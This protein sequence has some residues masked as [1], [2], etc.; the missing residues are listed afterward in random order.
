VAGAAS[1]VGRQRRPTAGPAGRSTARIADH[2]MSTRWAARAP[3]GMFLCNDC[4]DKFTVRTGAVF[5]RSHIPVAQ[6]AVG[7][8][9]DGRERA[10]IGP[11]NVRC[12]RSKARRGS[13]SHIVSLAQTSFSSEV[14]KFVRWQRH[15]AKREVNRNIN[16]GAVRWNLQLTIVRYKARYA[17]FFVR[18]LFLV[19]NA[20]PALH[21]AKPSILTGPNLKSR[22]VFFARTIRDKDAASMPRDPMVAVLGFVFGAELMSYLNTRDPIE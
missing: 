1:R 18:G 20:V 14:R 21:A 11:G 6:V 19:G 5:G 9:F 8:S 17:K 16:N 10:S 4:R 22:P 2:S 15:R 12:S 3:A 13:A 7:H